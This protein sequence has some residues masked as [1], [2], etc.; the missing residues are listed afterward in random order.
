MCVIAVS[1]IGQP[2]PSDAVLKKCWDN[3]ADGAGF[4]YHDG[5]YV[6]IRKGFM[7]F[8][9]F[10]NALADVISNEI[11]PIATSFVF[12][13]RIKTTGEVK[14]ECC[15]PFPLTQSHEELGWQAAYTSLGIAHNGTI[16]GRDTDKNTSDTMDYITSV[17]FTISSMFEGD[18]FIYDENALSLIEETINGSR[19]AMLTPYGYVA[20]VGEWIE[21]DGIYY[22]ND[23]YVNDRYAG[24]RNGVIKAGHTANGRPYTGYTGY[25]QTY[26]ET[27][28]SEDTKLPYRDSK[29][30]A[31]KPSENCFA[32]ENMLLCVR[33]QHWWCENA[34][35]VTAYSGVATSSLTN[36]TL[37]EA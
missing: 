12:H 11:D 18:T 2:L 7:T 33:N 13:F 24:W 28:P 26:P 22:S 30:I 36:S 20:M 31:M 3:N 14:P 19:M 32:C 17:L 10:S 9:A 29:F 4:M 35:E 37:V 8:E 23:S 5:E 16:L 15:H 21:D 6:Q 25:S 27:L 1:E 34:E